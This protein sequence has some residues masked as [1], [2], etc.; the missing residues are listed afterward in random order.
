[1]SGGQEARDLRRGPTLEEYQRFE[2]RSAQ[3]K[4]TDTSSGSNFQYGML[5]GSAALAGMVYN[6][7]KKGTKFSIPVYI[8]H[9]RLAVQSTVIGCL[10]AAMGYQLYGNIQ[11]SLE[12]ED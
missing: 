1:M 4:L 10:V 5:L 9:T 12:K 6:F 3:D 2:A 7:R 8:I 11:K